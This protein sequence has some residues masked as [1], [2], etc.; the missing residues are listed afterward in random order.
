MKIRSLAIALAVSLALTTAAEARK[1]PVFSAKA[2]KARNK[3]TV[4][5]HT[6]VTHKISKHKLVKQK[7]KHAA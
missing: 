6:A 7:V 2:Q 1:K 5:K 3:A 4:R